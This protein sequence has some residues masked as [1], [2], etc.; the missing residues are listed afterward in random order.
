MP[1]RA[2]R[3]RGILGLILLLSAFVSAGAPASASSTRDRLSET[4]R[5]LRATRARLAEVKR[6]DAELVAVIQQLTGQLGLTRAR[7]SDAKGLLARIE[8]QMR[9]EERRLARLARERRARARLIESRAREL[10]IMGSGLQ[11]EALLGSRSIGEFIDRSSS[12]DYVMRFDRIALDD[13]ARLADQA[14]KTRAALARQRTAADRV[15]RQIAERAAEL[16]DVLETRRV[17]EATLAE[18][19][20]HYQQEVRDLEREQ[21]RI[22]ALIRARQSLAIGPVSR[23]GF[24]WPIRGRITSGYGYRWGGFHTGIDINCDTGDPIKASKG[25]RVIASEWG[26]GYGQMIIIDHGGGVSTLYAHLSR[27]YVGDGRSVARGARIGACGSTGRATG[28]H[29]HF[30]VRINGEH[31]NPMRFLP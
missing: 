2:R 12:L 26:G 7:L 4:R 25:G 3:L 28:S 8:A 14:H 18:Q 5:R 31:T 29:L 21:A 15:R 19:I 11:V 16:G 9:G 30:E 22:V 23:R 6:T 1:G 20:E 10:Y 13:L 17:A 24:I 27:R